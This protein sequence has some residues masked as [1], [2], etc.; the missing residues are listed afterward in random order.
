MKTTIY[1]P[2]DFNTVNPITKPKT[3]QNRRDSITLFRFHVIP[4][5]GINPLKLLFS[6][7]LKKYLTK[8]MQ[9]AIL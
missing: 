3:R 9:C 4:K 2:P 1:R 6:K 5:G 7:K 8:P